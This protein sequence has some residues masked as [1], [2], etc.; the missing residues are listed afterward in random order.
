M[1]PFAADIAI[2]LAM[3]VAV[4]LL[5]W[6][7]YRMSRRVIRFIR[8]HPA[9]IKWVVIPVAAIALA[10]VC[11]SSAGVDIAVVLWLT[12]CAPF[13]LLILAQISFWGYHAVRHGDAF[14]EVDDRRDVRI[15][16][17]GEEAKKRTKKLCPICKRPTRCRISPRGASIPYHI[18]RD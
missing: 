9:I 14:Y 13:V 1:S 8:W 12:F 3:W 5:A 18:I 11:A 2:T 6:Y 16:Y 17:R 4:A 7:V 15:I 10:W